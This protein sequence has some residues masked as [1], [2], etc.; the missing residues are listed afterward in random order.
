[1]YKKHGRH[2]I[3]VESANNQEQFASRFFNFMRKHPELIISQ[4][5]VPQINLKVGTA[6][7]QLVPLRA[8]PAMLPITKSTLWM[9]SMNPP[10][11]HY[12]M[13]KV[14]R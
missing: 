9:T 10:L 14:G 2:D 3:E 8:V 11:A 1:M 7:P 12:S 4:V 13:S 6:M 5:Y